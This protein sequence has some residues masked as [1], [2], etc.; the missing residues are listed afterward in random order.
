MSYDRLLPI[1]SVVLLRGG[2]KRLMI[3]GR[4]QARA[5]DRHV[6]DYSGCLFPEGITSPDGMY[7]FD[8]DAIESLFFVGFQDEEEL[9]FR[10]MRLA[11]LG[12]LHVD[13]DGRIVEG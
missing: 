7:F 4:V 13:E 5:G 2:E 9:A 10:M 1:G 12:E 6:Y 11:T 8:H 3:V